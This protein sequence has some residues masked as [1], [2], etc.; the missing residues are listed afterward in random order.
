MKNPDIAAFKKKRIDLDKLKN[1]AKKQGKEFVLISTKTKKQ[2]G[3]VAGTKLL[4]FHRHLV[5]EFE[6]CFEVKKE[7]FKYEGK[8]TGRGYF[9]LDKKDFILFSGP[10]ADSKKHADKFKA[11]HKKTYIENKRLFAKEE[12]NLTAKQFLSNWKKKNTGLQ[13]E[14]Q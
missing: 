2:E 7:G 4:K 13:K 8:R 6:K 14:H 10:L 1:A 12:I 9:I 3:D 11:E 5:H